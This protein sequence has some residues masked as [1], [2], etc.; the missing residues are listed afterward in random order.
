MAVANK[1]KILF[2]LLAICVG[3]L[4]LV[5]LEGIFRVFDF[6][7]P[8]QVVDTSSGFSGYQ[9]LF[10]LDDSKT[11]Y[12]TTRNRALY[13]GD[14]AFEAVKPEHI[15]RMFFLGGSTVRGRPFAVDSAFAK[16]VELELNQRSHS[17][18]YQSVN[19]GGLSY[20]SFRLKHISQEVLNYK[21]DLLVLATGHNEFLENRTFHQQ[22][23]Q[24]EARS[25]LESLRLVVWLRSMLGQD[26]DSFKDSSDQQL[27]EN[28]TTRLDEESGYASYHWDPQWKTE[29]TGQYKES[30]QAIIQ[31]CR[32]ANIPLVLVCLGSNLRD[33]PPF[34]SEFPPDL[35]TQNKQDFLDLFAQATDLANQPAVA[36]ERYKQCLAIT[37]QH[38]LLHYRIGRALEQTGDT[39]NAYQ[40]YLKAKDLDICPLRLTE[41]MDKIQRQ[42]ARKYHVPLVDARTTL[43]SASMAGIPGYEMYVDHV[44]PTLHGH[45]MIAGAIVDMLLEQDLVQVDRDM[46]IREYQSLYSDYL[47]SLPLAFFSNGARR[48][49]WLEDWARRDKQIVELKPFDLRG[50]LAVVHRQ[51]GFDQFEHA[52]HELDKTREKFG[53]ISEAVLQQAFTFHSHGRYQTARMLLEWLYEN[54]T[55]EI[56][57]QQIQYARMINAE[58]LGDRG[59]AILIYDNYF[60][61][62]PFEVS[63]NA[64]WREFM[65]D[66]WER[67]NLE[68]Q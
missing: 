33:C 15:F 18:S 32:T 48:V 19:C 14:Q 38:A 67:V 59:V 47:Q 34:K 54:E 41:E 16:W 39:K 62:L 53:N 10:S 29:V 8:Q 66:I 12:T 1:K 7:S 52:Q 68:N 5:L 4:P 26:V 43:E 11:T 23:Q 22:R 25:A 44:H 13:F 36:L 9:P 57:V 3:L 56:L 58:C 64:P 42:L 24:S 35:T 30:L 20:A 50:H 37:D 31:Q 6:A 46:D 65:P 45:Q 28:V 17:T 63:G 51:L 55:D 2:P 49:N 40:H 60:K 21:P 61:R 27:P